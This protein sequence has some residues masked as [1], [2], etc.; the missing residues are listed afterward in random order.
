[1]LSPDHLSS[2]PGFQATNS[3]KPGPFD[4]GTGNLNL[5]L[6]QPTGWSCV[7][8]GLAHTR[9]L[10][11]MMNIDDESILFCFIVILTN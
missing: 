1:M 8:L 9:T 5:G 11:M 6:V 7:G 3:H 2:G 4:Y 10:L